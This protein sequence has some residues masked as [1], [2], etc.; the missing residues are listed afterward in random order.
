MGRG[1][2][3]QTGARWRFQSTATKQRAGTNRNEVPNRT[4]SRTPRSNKARRRAPFSAHTVRACRRCRSDA[5]HC[6]G[7]HSDGARRHGDRKGGD[8]QSPLLICFLWAVF[9]LARHRVLRGDDDDG[10]GPG[11][12]HEGQGGEHDEFAHVPLSRWSWLVSVLPIYQHVPIR[13]MTVS[14]PIASRWRAFH[15]PRFAVVPRAVRA[16]WTASTRANGGHRRRLRFERSCYFISP[17]SIQCRV[18]LR[19]Q[20]RPWDR[21]WWRFSWFPGSMRASRCHRKCVQRLRRQFLSP[22]VE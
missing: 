22:R 2:S 17:S 20:C 5:H 15:G 8:S 4:D 14:A 1:L 16:S 12:K 9:A 19:P 21:K 6:D 3:E 18:R 11:C 13:S 7:R 10:R